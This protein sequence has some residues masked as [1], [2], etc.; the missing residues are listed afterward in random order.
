M[1][2]EFDLV[3]RGGLLAGPM[4]VF[5]ADI[6]VRDGMIVAVGRGLRRGRDEVDA[7]GLIV[8]PGGIDPHCHIEE[9]AQD[10]SVH[11]ESFVSGTTAALAGG[12]TSIICFLPQWKGHSIAESAPGYEARAQAA[13]ADYSFHQVITDPTQAVLREELPALV[14]R[15]I[16]S[17]KVFLTY[18]PLK[19]SDGEFLDVLTAARRTGAL[20]TVHC[21]NYD[22]IGWRMRALLAAGL[23]DPL[24]HAWARPPVVEREATH[25]AIALAELVDQP[26]QI[27]HVSCE[28]AAAEIAR[29]RA[30]GVK[31]W[32]ET[33]PQYLTLST[34]DLSRPGFEGAKFVCSPALR[35]EDERERVW[36]RIQAGTLDVVS[37]DHCGY[38]YASAKLAPSGGY[39][40]GDALQRPDG[41]PAFNAIPNGVPGI[42]TRM[43]VLF[44]EGVAT[45]RIDLP[46]FVR[47]SSYNAAQLFGLSGRKGTLAPGA[48]ADLVIWNP[49]AERVIANSA[50][51]HAIDYTPWEGSAVKGAPVATIR[52]G[53]IA[54]REGEVL[55][56]PGSGRF[57]A[58][59]PYALAKPRGLPPDGFDAAAYT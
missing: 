33:C 7:K 42:E 31:V 11:E 55:A 3:V 57:L 37:S 16:R 46:A 40:Q 10:G 43:A 24:Q 6:A 21:E 8:M 5:E 50:L 12:T 26:L 14:A 56:Q 25:R 22:A 45:G 32:G 51:H 47:L 13:L 20:V 34:E 35:A 54:V 4:E 38:S 53:E 18:D 27:F 49:D 41:T 59:G 1:E 19:L 29:A 15:G 2:H 48:D 30:R 28:E 9:L 23:T 17:L 36:K 58:R 39:G 52:R 44:S